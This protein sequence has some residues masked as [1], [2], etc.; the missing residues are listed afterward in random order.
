MRAEETRNPDPRSGSKFPEYLR[1]GKGVGSACLGDGA[2]DADVVG[3]VV[4]TEDGGDGDGQDRHRQRPDR[5]HPAKAPASINTT[6]LRQ[7]F[8]SSVSWQARRVAADT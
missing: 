1:V 2:D 5:T 3:R 7:L 6:S 4:Q 8:R